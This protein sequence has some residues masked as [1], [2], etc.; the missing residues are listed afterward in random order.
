[1]ASRV[2]VRY[3]TENA[4]GPLAAASRSNTQSWIT[5]T[6]GTRPASTGALR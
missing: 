2:A 3:A 5:E 4:D 6:T 1:M